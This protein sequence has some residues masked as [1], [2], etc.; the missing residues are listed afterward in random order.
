MGVSFS[1]LPLS[2]CCHHAGVVFSSAGQSA[3][4]C[5]SQPGSAEVNPPAPVIGDGDG[6]VGGG[7]IA[8]L[9]H[10]MGDPDRLLLALRRQHDQHERNVIQPVNAAGKP[11]DQRVIE[12]HPAP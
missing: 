12:P 10:E 1:C 5:W 7:W 6:D 8:G 3:G 11:P 9:R 4:N 2:A